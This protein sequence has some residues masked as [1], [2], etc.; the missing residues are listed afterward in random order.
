MESPL[1]RSFVTL[2]KTFVRK[3]GVPDQRGFSFLRVQK[4][5][6]ECEKCPSA[7][8]TKIGALCCSLE[9]LSKVHF[10]GDAR[11]EQNFFEVQMLRGSES[12]C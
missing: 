12:L 5:I 9:A 10:V 8:V 1:Y 7:F 4:M 6:P 11:S 2:G 3:S